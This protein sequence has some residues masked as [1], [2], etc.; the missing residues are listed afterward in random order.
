M[1]K[2]YCLIDKMTGRLAF[3]P[4]AKSLLPLLLACEY[5]RKKDMIL[6]RRQVIGA[7]FY[8]LTFSRPCEHLLHYCVCKM[9]VGT[10]SQ[11]LAIQ[12]E[13]LLG[14]GRTLIWL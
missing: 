2:A 6:K 12:L 11:I 13:C 1:S 4:F 7:A 8:R 3:L 9:A 5:L 14:Y 10:G